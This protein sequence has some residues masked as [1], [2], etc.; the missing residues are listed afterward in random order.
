MKKHSLIIFGLL[1]IQFFAGYIEASSCPNVGFSSTPASSL[2]CADATLTISSIN[3]APDIYTVAVSGP[4]GPYA[5]FR[6]P[7]PGPISTFMSLATDS[8]GI[9]P[10]TYN[11]AVNGCTN[12]VIVPNASYAL[13][14]GFANSPCGCNG[15]IRLILTVGNP[16]RNT[17][18]TFTLT[19]PNGYNVSNTTGIFPFLC[20]GAYSGNVVVRAVCVG[21]EHEAVF[22]PGIPISFTIINDPT[23]GPVIA[24]LTA[25]PSGPICAGTS[26]QLKVNTITNAGNPIT[27]NWST[28]ASTNPITVT[29]TATT[30]YSVTITDGQGCTSNSL[31][32]LVV[33][34]ANPVVTTTPANPAMFCGGSSLTITANAT[35]GSGS[36]GF[37]WLLNG[38]VVSSNQ[39][40][41][42]TSV[43][44]PFA[45]Y[46]VIA[47]DNVSGCKG[48]TVV[49]VFEENCCSLTA[50]VLGIVSP[51]ACNA[52]TGVI[53]ITWTGGVG[54]VQYLINNVLIGDVPGNPSFDLG[55]LGTGFITIGLRDSLY[56]TCPQVN[57]PTFVPT[58]TPPTVTLGANFDICGLV[59]PTLTANITSPGAGAPYTFNWTP[60]APNQQTISI[61]AAGT[62]SVTV[63]DKNGCTSAP[64]SVVVNKALTAGITPASACIALGGTVTLTAVSTP[65]GTFNYQWKQGTTVVQNGPN[66]S[67]VVSTPATY[68][69]TIT[70]T[71][72]CSATATT[73]VSLGSLAFANGTPTATATCAGQSQGTITV[74]ITGGVGPNFTYSDSI[75]SFTTTATS[76]T[77]TGLAANTYTVTVTD[78]GSTCSLSQKVTVPSDSFVFINGTPTAKGTCSGQSNG[79]ITVQTGGG[80]APYIFSLDGT[81]RPSQTSPNITFTGVAGGA[82]TVSGVDANNCTVSAS[83]LV[84][85]ETF[86]FVNGTPTSTP[87]C[88]NQSTGTITVNTSGGS[89]FYQFFLDG[90]PVITQGSPN[91]VYTNVSGGPHTV[92]VLDA[93]NCTV[94]GSVTVQTT[95][96]TNVVVVGGCT[97]VV[98]ISGNASPGSTITVTGLPVTVPP[99]VT[100]SG[101]FTIT[102]PGVSFGTYNVTVTATNPSTPNCSPSVTQTIVVG[103]ATLTL[104]LDP[105][106]T[107]IPAR[108]K[109]FTYF[110]IVKNT[111]TSPATNLTVDDV[112]PSC[113]KFISAQTV[114][115]SDWTFS[116][117]GQ[118]VTATLPELDPGVTASFT[119]TVKVKCCG[120]KKVTNTAT[121]SATGIEPVTTSCVYCVE[122]NHS[123]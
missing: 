105:C 84:P 9:L 90:N 51:S 72:G 116:T 123:K 1:C 110:V 22:E 24:D 48:S 17:T 96:L 114:S 102:V 101:S 44:P 118:T 80:T 52:N 119:I 68:T 122:K 10:G 99:V 64:S 53:S 49:S 38:V 55:G 70:D 56:P 4:G 69:V 88:M 46:E 120:E 108:E 66:P 67:L 83:V 75:T 27:F 34:N 82:H 28:G 117:S 32:Q 20:P 31:S 103:C 54:Q 109:A 91:F 77:F 29:P 7:L 8:P 92:S 87:T 76:H 111:G 39:S 25:T 43:V 62:Y 13:T 61:S 47:T 18:T 5:P 121:L 100:V 89:A 21:S 95:A 85:T 35:G 45:L 97:D 37:Q 11:V 40:I 2:S 81:A 19:G 115:G 78:S 36:Y 57:T 71:N 65:T 98:T 42:V 59:S 93:N 60:P 3:F 74:N 94:S 73:T 86:I 113:F 104:V 14:S 6:A 12:M 15:I 33:V 26:V 23:L 107:K 30:N 79:S 50:P 106:D 58:T 63:T 112:L 41:V 16:S